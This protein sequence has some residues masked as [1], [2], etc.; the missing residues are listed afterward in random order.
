MFFSA[1]FSSLEKPARAC[2]SPRKTGDM[3]F[4]ELGERA[5]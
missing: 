5:K 3:I 4:K 2:E 1:K